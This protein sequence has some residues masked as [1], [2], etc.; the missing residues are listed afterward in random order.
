MKKIYLIFFYLVALTFFSCNQAG[1]SAHSQ[2]HSHEHSA[3]HDHKHAETAS[4]ES[5]GLQ[6]NNG[7]KWESDEATRKA[8]SNMQ[9]LITSFS[10]ATPTPAM[11][12]YNKLGND[13]Q[14]ELDVLFKT[15]SMKGEAHDQLHVLLETVIADVKTLKGD[16]EKAAME[17]YQSLPEHLNLFNTYFS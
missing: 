15:C 2:D 10:A 12:D 8:F 1:N 3:D 17:A 11:A 13:L 5:S 6:L 9:A 14:A 16:D 7:N 4:T